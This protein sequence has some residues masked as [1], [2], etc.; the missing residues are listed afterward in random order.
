MSE[1]V[2]TRIQREVGLAAFGTQLEGLDPWVVDRMTAMLVETRVRAGQVLWSAGE[3]AEF[4]YFMFDGRAQSRASRARGRGPTTARWFLGAFEGLRRGACAKDARS[5]HRLRPALV[6]PD[7]VVRTAGGQLRACPHRDQRSRVL[8]RSH[9]RAPCPLLGGSAASRATPRRR[10]A[11]RRRAHR[12]P[13]RGA[14]W[15][16]VPG[17]RCWPIWRLRRRRYASATARRC[18]GRERSATSCTSSSAGASTRAALRPTPPGATS[19]A[20]RRVGGASALSGPRASLDGALPRGLPSSL[21]PAGGLVRPRRGA[22][23]PRLVDPNS[24]R[25]HAAILH[26]GACSRGRARGARASLSPISL[27]RL[28]SPRSRL[29]CPGP[30]R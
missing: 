9:G 8:R 13:H 14:R 16:G 17:C 24:V 10:A 2:A 3:P 27:R 23:R 18:F 4:L 21:D 30:L 26:G 28:A 5:A 1:T 15:R 12:V 29:V 25:A 20:T 7:D 22:H 11:E 19:P 6:S